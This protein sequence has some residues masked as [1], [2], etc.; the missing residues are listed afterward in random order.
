MR[1]PASI[2][3]FFSRHGDAWRLYTHGWV[4]PFVRQRLDANGEAWPVAAPALDDLR[5][6][7]WRLDCPYMERRSTTGGV[8]L[9]AR[10]RSAV[11]IWEWLYEHIEAPA[12]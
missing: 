4:S 10:G 12:R 2:E 7:M 1:A 6:Y 9:E 11:A 3:I 8:A 5:G